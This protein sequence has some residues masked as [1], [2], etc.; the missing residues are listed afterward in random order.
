MSSSTTYTDDLTADI[1]VGTAIRAEG[2]VDADGTSLDATTVGADKGPGAGGPGGFGGRGPGGPG[3]H[4]GFGGPRPEGAGP[5]DGTAPDG[6]TPGGTAPDGSTDGSSP[7]P[8]T[9]PAPSTS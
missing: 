2:A 4:G 6:S 3:G 8:T 9:E 5:K 1:A 7:A